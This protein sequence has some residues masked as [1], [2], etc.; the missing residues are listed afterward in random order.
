V[1]SELY[2]N[3]AFLLMSR[4]RLCKTYTVESLNCVA[5]SLRFYLYSIILMMD[6]N[7]Q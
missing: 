5:L 6:F 7:L 2:E 1:S 4:H 3:I